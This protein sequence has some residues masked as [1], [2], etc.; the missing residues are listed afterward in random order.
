MST[1]L[2]IPQT[3]RQSDTLVDAQGRP[4]NIYHT[5]FSTLEKFA[6]QASIA[7]DAN[8]KADQA[9]ADALAAQNQL[10]GLVTF[11]L[12]DEGNVVGYIK[13]SDQS[14]EGLGLRLANMASGVYLKPQVFEP[15]PV[16]STTDQ[17]TSQSFTVTELAAGD[18]IRFNVRC[19][20]SNGAGVSNGFYL[21][22][23]PT[24]SA[25]ETDESERYCVTSD[26][27]SFRVD[28]FAEYIVPDTIPGDLLEF[29]WYPAEDYE[30][31]HISATVQKR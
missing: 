31:V 30:W 10:N 27:T 11:E 13:Q 5:F 29:V 23:V 18:T 2:I 8:A 7:I 15:F 3:P 21:R 9:L 4:T 17:N 1:R 28:Q 19:R 25:T 12:D 6:Q 22:D 14:S 16:S 24:F 26:Q 20:F